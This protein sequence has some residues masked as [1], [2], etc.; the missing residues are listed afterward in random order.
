MSI[1]GEHQKSKKAAEDHQHDKSAAPADDLEQLRVL[2]HGE[3]P[4]ARDSC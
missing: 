3:L 2:D 1:L 4:L